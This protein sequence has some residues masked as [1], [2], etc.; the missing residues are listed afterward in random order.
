MRVL[1]GLIVGLVL[2]VSGA[3]LAEV[4]ASVNTNGVLKGYTVQKDVKTICKD[5]EVWL[6]FRGQGSFI[7]CD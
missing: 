5:P 1:T 6:D 2:G 4:I 3:A 7:V